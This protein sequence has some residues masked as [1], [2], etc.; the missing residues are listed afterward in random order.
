MRRQDSV[1]AINLAKTDLQVLAALSDS[2]S[3][4]LVCAQR[5]ELA[6]RRAESPAVRVV[7]CERDLPDGNWKSVF[8][9][10]RDLVHAPRFIVVSRLADERLWAEVLNLGGYDV[11]ATPLIREEVSRV[12]SYAMDAPLRQAQV[13]TYSS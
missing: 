5:L 3:W 10:V 7:L 12:L 1:L 9:Q 6:L 11:L 13:L 2:M 8:E 4:K